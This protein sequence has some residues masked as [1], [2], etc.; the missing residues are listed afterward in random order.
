MIG[1]SCPLFVVEGFRVVSFAFI[2]LDAELMSDEKCRDWFGQYVFF[3]G[4]E[5]Y[6]FFCY[7]DG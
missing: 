7:G 5:Q 1:T 2:V 3:F 4:K 6:I